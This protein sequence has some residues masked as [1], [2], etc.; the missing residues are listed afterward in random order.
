M[1]SDSESAALPQHV[2]AENLPATM[3]PA[4]PTP[5]PAS[6]SAVP[7]APSSSP[8]PAPTSSPAPG[9]NPP[10]PLAAPEVLVQVIGEPMR[11]KILRELA[12]GSRPA[13]MDLAKRLDCH[14]DQMGRHLRRLSRAGLIR[15]IKVEDGDGRSRY[16]QIHSA[17]RCTLPDG[18]WEL[19][20]GVVA[21]R[22]DP[23]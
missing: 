9:P 4:P 2:P 17:Y 21:L 14:P 13:V 10:K 12:D 18:R 5:P 22:F 23:K 19:D 16:Y 3:A 7:L 15:R 11:W 1:D 6:P 8:L 20:Y